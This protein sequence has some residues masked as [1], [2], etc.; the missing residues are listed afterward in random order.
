MRAKD[1]QAYLIAG[2]LKRIMIGVSGFG[3]IGWPVIDNKAIASKTE[4]ETI[5]VCISGVR[6]AI[7]SGKPILFIRI[8]TMANY[9]GNDFETF[10]LYYSYIYSGLLVHVDNN[11][12]NIHLTT[13]FRRC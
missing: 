12:Y 9:K 7:I 10:C 3:R 6:D 8:L 5:Y 11:F 1:V 2:K 13:F 4:P